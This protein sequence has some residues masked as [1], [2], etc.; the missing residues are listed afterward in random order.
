[1]LHVRTDATSGTTYQQYGGGKNGNLNSYLASGEEGWLQ[2]I[3]Q[4]PSA[5]SINNTATT[6]THIEASIHHNSSDGAENK[7]EFGNAPTA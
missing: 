5:K 2:L 3:I 4:I 7:V 6:I 1:M